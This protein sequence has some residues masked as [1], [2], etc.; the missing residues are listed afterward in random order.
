M[1]SSKLGV[2]VS[3][4]SIATIIV[5]LSF[6]SSQRFTDH[7]EKMVVPEQIVVSEDMTIV[8]IARRNSLEENAI[9][10]ALKIKGSS[11]KEKT[12]KEL[13]ISEKDAR[14]K[15]QKVLNFK[16]EEAS[17]NVGLIAA[18]F[19]LWAIFMTSA[20]LLLK[21]NKMSPFIRK[22]MFLSSALLSGVVL[23]AEPN[24]MSTVKDMVSN[25][26]IKGILFPPRVIA[27]LVLLGTVFAANKF[28]CGWACQFGTLQD[29]IFRLNRDPKDKKGIF[30]QYKLPFYLS[31]T[32][33]ILFFILFIVIAFAWSF[34]SIE[35]INPFII[36]K[37]VALT[38]I[39]LVF[40]S[41]LLIASL[42]IYRPWCHLFCP[43]GLTGWI[44]ERFSRYRIKV[45]TTTC[46]NC[47]ECVIACPSN[48]MKAILRDDKVRPDCFSCGTC[49][50]TCSTKSITFDK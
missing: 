43:F 42:F 21:K 33:R 15:I 7:T 49:I 19:I 34:D 31:N 3:F 41:I 23:G 39:G 17:K 5:V 1:K 14:I 27:L 38:S 20:F 8:T 10:D 45:N 50:N 30:R 25:F 13:G 48:A 22:Y 36:F 2:I 9:Q 12:L 16:A 37:P 28:I 46:T 40:I 18:K 24:P 4:F 44:V 29:F 26:A 47:K 35:A 11:D 6:F 32:I